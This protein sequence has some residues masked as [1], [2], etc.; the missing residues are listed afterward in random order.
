ME[1]YW[2][3]GIHPDEGV[4]M[5]RTMLILKNLGPHDDSARFDHPPTTSMSSYDYPYFGQIF[6]AVMLSMIGYPNSLN[7]SAEDGTHS[8]EMLY[9]APRVL[10]E[11]LQCWI[12]F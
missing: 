3:S 12:L 4:Y 10:M 7:P 9:L 6:L 11:S 8:V 2:I 5:R 1:C